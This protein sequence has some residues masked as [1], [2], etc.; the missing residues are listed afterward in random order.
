MLLFTSL[1]WGLPSVC[2]CLH[3]CVGDGP[4][5]VS[6]YISLFG[7]ALSLYLFTFLCWGRPSACNLLHLSVEDALSLYLFT[8]LYLRRPSACICLHLSVGDVPQFVS[9]YISL[10]GTALS[11]YLSG[12]ST[13]P[14]VKL[15]GS[16][17][18]RV[19]SSGGKKVNSWSSMT[20][21]R[22]IRFRARVCPG[23]TRR[24][25]LNA[26]SLQGKGYLITI[27]S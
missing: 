20:S 27:V 7:T 13:I 23:H 16:I 17:L 11:L 15:R 14:M 4:Q 5:F 10:F 18:G 8:S 26:R 25:A 24:P 22:N 2:F 12:L 3:L 21:I 1:C 19:E 9:V 6:V